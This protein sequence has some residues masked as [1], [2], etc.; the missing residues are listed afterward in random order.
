MNGGTL[1]IRLG[2]RSYTVRKSVFDVYRVQLIELALLY[3]FQSVRDESQFKWESDMTDDLSRLTRR[4]RKAYHARRGVD[5]DASEPS[6][7]L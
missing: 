5:L 3:S 1:L 7:Q 6:I 2:L 4:V